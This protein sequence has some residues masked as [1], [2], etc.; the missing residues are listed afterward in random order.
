VADR[1]TSVS[2]YAANTDNFYVVNDRQVEGGRFDFALIGP[3]SPEPSAT[4]VPSIRSPSNKG[5]ILLRFLVVGSD[6]LERIESLRPNIT[7]TP[8]EQS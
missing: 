3:K 6:Q 2:L 1:Y 8:L 7:C 5:L 4:G